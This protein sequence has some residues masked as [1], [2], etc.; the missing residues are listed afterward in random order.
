MSR[1]RVPLGRMRMDRQLQSELGR[2]LGEA[3]TAAAGQQHPV[4]SSRAALSQERSPPPRPCSLSLNL[5]ER[6]PSVFPWDSELP[7]VI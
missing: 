6:L 3:R 5:D 4:V 1:V 7:F 2:S